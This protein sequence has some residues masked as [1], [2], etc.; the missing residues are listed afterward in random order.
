MRRALG[1]TNWFSILVVVAACGGQAGT[2]LFSGG[3]G[4]SGTGGATGAGSAT[5][6]SATMATGGS[7]T[8]VTGGTGQSSGSAG[9]IGTGGSAGLGGAGGKGGSTSAGSGGLSS[10]GTAGKGSGGLVAGGAAS[11][12]AAGKGGGGMPAGGAA[13]AG[14]AGKG[15]GG[16]VAGG[17]AGAG[18]QA[19]CE[20]VMANLP[21]LLTAAQSCDNSLDRLPCTGFVSNECG[22]KVPVDL[23]NSSVT[24]IYL[25][26][27]AQVMKCGVV[28]PDLICREPTTARCQSEGTQSM[29]HCVAN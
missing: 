4:G 29:G 12:G 22:C 11:A 6:G 28:C 8:T 19:T 14:A 2:D 17:A 23:A 15:S 20:M 7:A 13:S 3:S 27:V 1:K 5:G 18:G 21:K 16:V 9:M 24:Q 26:A 10:A 25:N